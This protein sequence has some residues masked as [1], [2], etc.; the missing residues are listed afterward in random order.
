MTKESAY[1]G[2]LD[3]LKDRTLYGWCYKPSEPT[4]PVAVDLFVDNMLVTRVPSYEYRE[5]L[6]KAGKGDGR[7][8]F[9]YD[10]SNCV[11]DDDAI[12]MISTRVSG[13]D[14]ELSESPILV[15]NSDQIS[16]RCY[17]PWNN[18]YIGTSG[19]VH[20]CQCPSWLGSPNYSI[21]DIKKQSYD[22]LWNGPKI[23]RYR[24]AFIKDNH[25]KFCRESICPYLNGTDRQ[26]P[27]GLEVIRAINNRRM[28]LDFGA[29][30]LVYDVNDGCN[31]R[32][33]MCRKD[34]KP[35]DKQAVHDAVVNIREIAL[36]GHLQSITVSGAGEVFLFDEFI[37]LLRSD[38]FSS[39]GITVNLISNLTLFTPKI[40]DEIKHNKIVLSVS[41]DGATKQT[42]ESIRRGSKWEN[43]HK[44]L[45]YVADLLNKG[46][47]EVV[48]LGCVITSKNAHEIDK[49]I[50]LVKE[51]GFNL[52]FLSHR[53]RLP[54]KWDNIFE[55]CDIEKLDMVHDLIEG[56]GGFDINRIN[57]GSCGIL[58]DRKYRQFSYR[59]EMADYQMRMYGDV[60]MANRIVQECVNDIND[61]VIEV[62]QS[63]LS[64]YA[65][66]LDTRSYSGKSPVAV[67]KDIH[68][69]ILAA[70]RAEAMP[71]RISHIVGNDREQQ[72]GKE[73]HQG[74]S[75]H[76]RS[77]MK[78]GVVHRFIRR[79]SLEILQA[80]FTFSRKA[81]YAIRHGLKDREDHT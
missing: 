66:F 79:T 67:L 76:D 32:C 77:G 47:I 57:L 61:G 14:V 22:Q 71:R 34:I 54:T 56:C 1:E 30:D 13:T 12:H 69:R 63:Q 35:V 25:K 27:P 18:L 58:K 80:V 64:G 37:D 52:M 55:S 68:A 38:F 28:E 60:E 19:Q 17:F 51:L 8:S 29:S 4:V 16:I 26:I 43:V 42:Y 41:V 81:L 40:W 48:N 73:G 24:E 2:Y 21:G 72:L 6:L 9:H 65:K 75:T 49:V 45:V 20:T 5:D 23:R 78:A 36:A 33:I 74:E 31:L 15:R 70:N 53:G 59:M 7:H 39:H 50:E 46:E 11:P 10:M 44:K 62:D 3:G